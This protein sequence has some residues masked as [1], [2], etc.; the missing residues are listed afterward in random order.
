[1]APLLKVPSALPDPVPTAAPEPLFLGD[2]AD[3]AAAA[4]DTVTLLPLPSL[5]VSLSSPSPLITSNDVATVSVSY[6]SLET[7]T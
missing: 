6:P 2:A 4:A 3:A 7:L 5:S 1:M